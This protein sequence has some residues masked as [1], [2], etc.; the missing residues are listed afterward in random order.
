MK[1]AGLI[2]LALGVTGCASTVTEYRAEAPAL[3][4]VTT[5]SPDETVRCLGGQFEALGN[6]ATLKAS[7]VGQT[8]GWPENTRMFVDVLPVDGGTRVVF[9]KHGVLFGDHYTAAVARCQD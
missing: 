4:Y 2:A 8:L 9:H 3:E 5:K 7:S 1:T 6:A